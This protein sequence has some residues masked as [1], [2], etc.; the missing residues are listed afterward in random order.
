MVSLLARSDGRHVAVAAEIDRRLCAGEAM[1][2]AAHT[3]VEAYAVLTSWPPPRR[4]SPRDARTLIERNF[5]QAAARV[6]DLDGP[7]YVDLLDRLA[8]QGIASGRVYDAIIA[9]CAE[10]AGVSVLLTFNPA[11]FR[12]LVESAMEVVEPV[13]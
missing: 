10:H 7:G 4:L 1:V 3:L 9:A 2:V 11:H 5:V 6:V 8:T 13:E 12:A